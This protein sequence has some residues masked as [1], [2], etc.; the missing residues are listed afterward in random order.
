[1]PDSNQMFEKS[2]GDTAD[3]FL[4]CTRTENLK[5]L[6]I[7]YNA[8]SS[9]WKELSGAAFVVRRRE[10]FRNGVIVERKFNISGLLSVREGRRSGSY[11]ARFPVIV[12]RCPILP[13]AL[14]RE[15]TNLS[16]S[17]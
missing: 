11:L 4:Q 9:F 13:L 8:K 15:N 1:M 6:I 10:M 2:S 16:S 17:S 7:S 5:K 14:P 3:F 12:P